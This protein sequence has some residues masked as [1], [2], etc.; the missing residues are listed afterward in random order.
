[1]AVAVAVMPGEIDGC[2]NLH[3]IFNPL[4]YCCLECLTQ[5]H[6]GALLPI[7]QHHRLILSSIY[8]HQNLSCDSVYHGLQPALP[9]YYLIFHQTLFAVPRQT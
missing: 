7:I 2:M 6:D 4:L 8:V 3:Q 5:G 1:M 9:H